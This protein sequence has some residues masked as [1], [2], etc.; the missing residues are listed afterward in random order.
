MDRELQNEREKKAI[1]RLKGLYRNLHDTNLEKIAKT[2]QV[3]SFLSLCY[4]GNRHKI[5][6]ISH[7]DILVAQ[8]HTTA[9]L[10]SVDR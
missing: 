8:S 6:P 7:G 9:L 10:N 2:T 1:S 4:D 5:N 3:H